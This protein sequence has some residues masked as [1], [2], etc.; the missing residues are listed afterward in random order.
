GVAALTMLASCAYAPVVVEG[1]RPVDGSGEGGGNPWMFVPVGIW[2]TRD[3]VVPRAVG[4]C[5][6]ETCPAKVAVA[7]FEARGAEARS[8]ARSLR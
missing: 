1:L 8:L 6:T 7:V 5:E 2:L 3:T 4:M